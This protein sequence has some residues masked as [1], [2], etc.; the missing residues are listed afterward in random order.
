MSAG[1]VQVTRLP[2]VT[3]QA[4]VQTAP[5]SISHNE[6]FGPFS[7]TQLSSPPAS[8]AARRYSWRGPS[9]SQTR[10][11][12]ALFPPN[13][14]QKAPKVTPPRS[15]RAFALLHRSHLIQDNGHDESFACQLD[16]PAVAPGSFS[17][18]NA[19]GPV[20]QTPAKNQVLCL[21]Q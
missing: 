5:L 8:S 4:Y 15:E 2:P 7:R 1:G 19:S 9:L 6:V 17:V 14:V 16:G 3:H 18:S 20:F 11:P 21:R 12:A 13:A 10:Q